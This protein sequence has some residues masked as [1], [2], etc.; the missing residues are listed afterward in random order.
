MAKVRLRLNRKVAL[1]TA[2]AVVTLAVVACVGHRVQHA[3]S[4]DR[5]RQTG[6]TA[7]ENEDWETGASHLK[8]YLQYT[9]DD[10]DAMEAYAESLEAGYGQ[11]DEAYELR[12]QILQSDPDRHHLRRRQVE[13]ALKRD[14]ID[15][16]ARHAD[17][18]MQRR[19]DVAEH[20]WL[21]GRVEESR[22]QWSAAVRHYDSAIRMEPLHPGANRQ[23]AW[24]YEAS[25]HRQRADRI[26]ARLLS[27]QQTDEVTARTL[28]EF[29]FRR[30]RLVD[31]EPYA[32]RLVESDDPETPLLLL[33]TRIAVRLVE[34]RVA[35]REHAIAEEVVGFWTKPVS[36]GIER[37]PESSFFDVS[38][39]S[40]HLAVGQSDEA[41]QVYQSAIER[42]PEDLSLRFQVAW[43]LI[44]LQKLDEAR[45]AI[46]ALGDLD[47][48]GEFHAVLGGAL[49]LAHGRF[50]AARSCFEVLIEQRD[51]DSVLASFVDS[52][53]ATACA[54]LGQWDTAADA[55]Q[56]AV[57]R[58]PKDR[59]ARFGLALSRLVQKQP[60]QALRDLQKIP[61]LA[62]LFIE[63]GETASG[64]HSPQ[65]L[66]SGLL[67]Q[68][69]SV[70]A[71]DEAHLLHSLVH[72]SNGR[73]NEAA[74]EL[75]ASGRQQRLFDL[76]ALVHASESIPLSELE[77]VVTAD[78]ADDRALMTLFVTWAKTGKKPRI[79]QAIGHQRSAMAERLALARACEQA[80][81]PLRSSDSALA[82]RLLGVS[83]Q[84]LRDA[85]EQDP[86]QL[87][88]LV[89]FLARN[90]RRDDAFELCRE[91]WSRYPAQVAGVWLAL[92]QMPPASLQRLRELER[93]VV[94]ELRLRSNSDALRL[95]LADVY[96]MTGRFPQA[97]KQ[98]RLLVARN[99]SGV[100]G[101]NNLAWLLAMQN[102]DVELALRLISK[103]I[104][105]GGETP[106]LVDTRGC[107]R[108]ARGDTS[109]AIQDFQFAAKEKP[110]PDVYFHL[111]VARRRSGQLTEATDALQ[112]ARELGFDPATR[113]PLEQSLVI[114][115]SEL[116][117]VDETPVTENRSDGDPLTPA[118]EFETTGAGG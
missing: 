89:L 70:I 91:S 52:Q 97:E 82:D 12:E 18:L 76:I 17:L 15:S 54:H 49:E 37:S 78:P 63:R 98:Y 29:L 30:D 26:I 19:P 69:A 81:V 44:R 75:A 116:D 46:D 38:L 13:V 102:R 108:L 80:G 79:E 14:E 11:H 86:R 1:I 105:E 99:A 45:N 88:Q 56:R 110:G 74:S 16:A 33:G 85:V 25:G 10:V 58:S 61:N 40:L 55:W 62:G 113:S 95:V 96:L 21:K 117:A 112:K 3:M 4:V 111:A 6:L 109:R 43:Q 34:Q 35:R 94:A 32:R 118:D 67:D 42:I 9:R 39:A 5:A 31:A 53:Y 103:A 68:S 87:P 65:A 57:Q 50:E 51:G 84:I 114:E 23:L 90:N 7:V 28:A 8:Y 72:I 106:G 27:G 24:L 73:V 83:E 2:A 22:K 104:S 60:A 93:N 20:A 64:T 47:S 92:T 36:L 100:S 115:V 101:L 41:M 59:E 48:A 77:Q 71:K 66:L 107:V